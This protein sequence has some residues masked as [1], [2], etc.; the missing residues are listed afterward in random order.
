MA[1]RVPSHGRESDPIDLTGPQASWPAAALRLWCE[2]TEDA[3]ARP[4]TWHPPPPQ[5]EYRLREVL[6]DILG[7]D[8]DDVLITSGVRAGASV[9]ARTAREVL[10]ERPSFSGTAAVLRTSHPDLE[11]V[12]WGDLPAISASPPE[13]DGDRLVWL[14]TPCRNPDG[15]TLSA[16]DWA[17]L[18]AIARRSRMVVNEVYRW[19]GSA[20]QRPDHVWMTGS[21]SKLAGGGAGLGW[22]RGPDM[23]VLR[24]L[25]H[26]RPSRCWQRCWCYLL[27]RGVLELFVDQT[28][29]PAAAAAEAFATEL[30]R[31]SDYAYRPAAGC[32]WPPF[33]LLPVPTSTDH[34]FVARL[35]EAGV[36]VG[37]GSDFLAATPGVRVCFV[38]VSEA[39]ARH[40]AR[41]IGAQLAAAS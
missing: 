35:D 15:A 27:E 34:E 10:H 39:D 12:Q 2:A 16:D 32:W 31:V 1:E 22:I 20:V 37:P 25:Q 11:L 21:L 36:R 3:L 40:A 28:V 26:A 24:R 8:P 33:L 29:R 9:I 17:C 38:G 30:R 41:V 23:E 6:G 7:E 14:T 18:T 5:G 13:R 19:F 4:D